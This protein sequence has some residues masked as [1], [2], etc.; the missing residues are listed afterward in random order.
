MEKNMIDKNTRNC[1]LMKR[2]INII[3]MIIAVI[4]AQLIADRYLGGAFGW[5]VL[6]ML[7][8]LLVLTPLG[9]WLD[10]KIESY[11]AKK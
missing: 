5:T 6:I 4:I 3:Q 8:I 2:I 10:K 9:I 1:N 7:F 11:Y